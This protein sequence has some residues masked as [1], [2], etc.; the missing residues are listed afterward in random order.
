MLVAAEPVVTTTAPQAELDDD[1]FEAFVNLLGIQIAHELG[2]ATATH[3][4]FDAAAAVRSHAESFAAIIGHVTP[5]AVDRIA[6]A[7][8]TVMSAYTPPPERLQISNRGTEM[9]TKK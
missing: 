8:M 9:H 7:V 6:A 4:P 2:L 3:Q 1:I 5:G